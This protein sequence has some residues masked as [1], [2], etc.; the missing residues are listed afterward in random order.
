MALTQIDKFEMIAEKCTH[1][2]RY[3]LSETGKFETYLWFCD[4]IISSKLSRNHLSTQPCKLIRHLKMRATFD[5]EVYASKRG[6]SFCRAGI[7]T[8]QA[9]NHVLVLRTFTT[10]ICG[11]WKF[12]TRHSNVHIA[13]PKITR[14]HY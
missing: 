13:Q 11:K 14:S 3:V 7:F 8:I 6:L 5:I 12:G 1:V 9:V 4:S 10:K 2:M